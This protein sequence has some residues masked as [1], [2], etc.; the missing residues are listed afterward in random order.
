MFGK[1]TP[2][3]GRPSPIARSL[4]RGILLIALSATSAWAQGTA[5]PSPA[6]PRGGRVVA[7]GGDWGY[8]PYEYLDEAAKPRGFNIDLVTKIAEVE[9]FS[10]VLSLSSWSEARA[11]L[12]RGDVDML[13]GMYRSPEREAV[14]DF[15]SPH[16][17]T[18]YRIFA[19]KGTSI[20]SVEDLKG[21]RVAAQK[22][23]MGY[24]FLIANDVSPSIVVEDWKDLFYT[25]KSGA[26]DCVVSS[27]LQGWRATRDRSFARIEAVGPPLFVAEYCMAVREGDAE[28][29][30][31]LNEGLSI[32]KTSGEYDAIYR[33]WFGDFGET[34][35]DRPLGLVAALL[36]IA[37]TLSAAAAIWTVTA[38][39]MVRK[40]TSE[41]SDELENRAET[42]ARLQE[43]LLGADAARQEAQRAAQ[44]KTAFVAWVSHELRTPLH[45]IL[46]AT[47]L[48]GRTGL[49]EEQA[50]TLSMARS[51]AEQLFRIL[52]DLL[53]AVGSNKG[54]LSFERVEF[55]FEDF[56]SWL[57]SVLRPAA[58]ERGLAFRF[59][60]NGS[61]RRILADKN[62]IAQVIMNLSMNAIKYTDRGEV[63][64]ALA[65]HEDSLY[66]SVKDTGP[67][68]PD[69]AKDKIFQPYYRV[70]RKQSSSAGG[71]G[72]GLAIVKSI[73]DALGGSIRYETHPSLGTHFEVSLPLS[74]A[75]P[76]GEAVSGARTAASGREAEPA[77][78]EP[79]PP[80]GTRAIVAEDEAINRLYLKRVLE[81]AGYEV[82]QAIDGE[83]ALEAASSGEWGFILMDV[84]MPR[85]DGLEA[86]RRIRAIEGER[87][88]GRVPII[89]LTAHAYAEDRQACTEAGMDG[90]L[91]K[92]FTESALWAEVRSV[93]ASLAAA[94]RSADENAAAD[95]AKGPSEQ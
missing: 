42:Q 23:D 30:A 14:A 24:E 41:L 72:L 43:A 48:L 16:F 5:A 60:A 56:A 27:A 13:A 80:S 91:S 50:K 65:L 32:L 6:A 66:I 25:I 90:F 58:E 36:A 81:S 12:D 19:P 70:D 93:T 78:A 54:S 57:E 89:A 76:E 8:P 94:A 10:V 4:Y 7:I 84:S 35:S 29:L 51:S 74:F 31:M 75:A 3:G 87:R 38:R 9:G 15:T 40:K 1:K 37:L 82:M 61:S 11:R 33:R 62:R 79:G 39:S 59:Q 95:A 20:A 86:T 49:D 63:E 46:G 44:E 34:G 21:L 55:S 22:D 71:L 47:E 92:P 18:V 2:S 67:G 88:S 64:L 83:A 45:G 68:I 85:M 69:E 53:D 28:L 73:V 17:S 26:A 52:S 77:P